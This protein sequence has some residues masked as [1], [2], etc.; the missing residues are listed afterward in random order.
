MNVNRLYLLIADASVFGLDIVCLVP[1]PPKPCVFIGDG[2][3]L[4]NM[5]FLAGGGDGAPNWDIPVILI[6]LDPILEK[7]DGVVFDLLNC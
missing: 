4:R 6:M 3:L 7:P 1:I 2:I 5:L